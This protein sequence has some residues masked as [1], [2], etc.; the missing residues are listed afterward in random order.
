MKSKI[1]TQAY[2]DEIYG[3]A[4][5]KGWWEKPQPLDDLLMLVVTELAEAVE[6]VRNKKPSFYYNHPAGKEPITDPYPTGFSQPLKP[7]G[8]A[9]ELADVWIR[10]AD[11]MG[12]SDIKLEELADVI[13]DT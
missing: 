4:Q 5:K 13:E 11:I 7:E 9:V 8:A 3:D 12:H 10:L 6:E 1:L 2:I